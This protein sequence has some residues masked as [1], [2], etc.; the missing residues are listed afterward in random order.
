MG[1]GLE[2]QPG[3]LQGSAVGRV[4][5]LVLGALSAACGAGAGQVLD[6]DMPSVSKDGVLQTFKAFKISMGI[7]Y[8]I[9]GRPASFTSLSLLLS[10]TA[11]V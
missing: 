5:L 1:G 9:G 7:K 6:A 10:P 2:E 3:T 8:P 4:R 11:C